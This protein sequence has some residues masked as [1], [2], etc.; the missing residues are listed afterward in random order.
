MADDRPTFRACADLARLFLKN[1]RLKEE[2]VVLVADM[3][4]ALD[5]TIAVFGGRIRSDSGKVDD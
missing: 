1:S 2:L 5:N 4:S 3:H